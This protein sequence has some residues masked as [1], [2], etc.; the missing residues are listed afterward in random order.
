MAW[1]AFM[2][3]WPPWPLWPNRPDDEIMSRLNKKNL[4]FAENAVTMDN[5][6]IKGSA[7]LL[8]SMAFQYNFFSK[9]DSFLQLAKK[10]SNEILTCHYSELPLAQ[11]KIDAIWL[12][13]YLIKVDSMT[14]QAPNG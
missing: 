14:R 6:W 10:L 2:A 11:I 3:S 9:E 13:L 5:S 7:Y 1:K 8:R 4:C 12:G